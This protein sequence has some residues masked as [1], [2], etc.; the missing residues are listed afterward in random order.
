MVPVSVNS[1]FV[2]R[3]FALINRN[4]KAETVEGVFGILLQ[5]GYL[6]KWSVDGQA[7]DNLYSL[8]SRGK[9]IAKRMFQKTTKG[10]FAYDKSQS[11]TQK[12]ES[13]IPLEPIAQPVIERRTKGKT[14][15]SREELEGRRLAAVKY[16]TIARPQKIA[17][18]LLFS[19][20]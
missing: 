1:S 12:T 14:S 10:V 18:F 19:V 11:V 20:V 15:L 17:T 3:S 4:I 13:D 16:A 5:G 9:R 2:Q 8:T 6:E 7:S